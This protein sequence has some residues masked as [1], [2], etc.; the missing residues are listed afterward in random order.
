MPKLVKQKI[1]KSAFRLRRNEEK[2]V[3]QAWRLRCRSQEATIYIFGSD[4]KMCEILLTIIST[5]FL[6]PCI[7]QV[8]SD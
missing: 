1:L 3:L 7:R 4:K 2:N 5:N 6:H 8:I